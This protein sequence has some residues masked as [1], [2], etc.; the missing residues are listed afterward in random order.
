[1]SATIKNGNEEG[2]AKNNHSVSFHLQLAV[3][4]DFIGDE[5]KLALC[6]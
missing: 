4:V 6:R 1:M 5:A 3:F 2:K